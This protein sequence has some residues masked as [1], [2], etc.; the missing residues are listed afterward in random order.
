[1]IVDWGRCVLF[2]LFNQKSSIADQ[3]NKIVEC[4]QTLIVSF[5]V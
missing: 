1:M 2:Y 5:Y 3:S 4:L